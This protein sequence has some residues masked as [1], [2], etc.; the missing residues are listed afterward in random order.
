MTDINKLTERGGDLMI[1]ISGIR[2]RVP[3]G[4]DPE[5]ILYFTRAFCAVT[6][7]KIVLGNDARPTGPI[8]RHLALGV[9][10]AAGKEVLDIGLAPT[11]T[12]KAAVALTRSHAGIMLSASHN[13]PE[14]NAFKF[15][16]PGGFFFDAADGERLLG[17]LRRDDF[18][19]QGLAKDYRGM[20]VVREYD[21]LGGHID[22]VLDIIPNLRAIRKKKYKVVV[23]AVAGAGREALPLLLEKLGCRVIPLFCEP[24]KRGEF[25]RPPEPTPMAL[26]KF[27]ALVKKKKAHIGFALDPDADRLVLGSPKRGAIHEEYTLPLAFLGMEEYYSRVSSRTKGGRRKGRP[28]IVNLSTANLLDAVSERAGLKVSRAPVGEANVVNAM[29]ARKACYGGEGNGGVI[30][31]GVPSYGRDPLVGAALT[32]SA[33]VREDKTL[34]ELMDEMPRLYMEKTKMPLPE[35]LNAEEIFYRLKKEFP[36][37]EVNEEDGLHITLPD[38]SWLHLRKSNTEPIIRLI[39]QGATSAKLKA[40]LILAASA[41]K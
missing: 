11:P 4:L 7:R 5:N 8:L 12:V 25:P 16:G 6:G 27:G 21:G 10:L 2:G 35:D 30:H 33:M 26:R 9:L 34:D 24:T 18:A 38:L 39:A 28:L 41:V 31:P 15:M 22:A 14:W 20:G 19:A 13:P 17:A 37:G 1:S 23:D 32:L 29:R 40:M 3:Q 36:E